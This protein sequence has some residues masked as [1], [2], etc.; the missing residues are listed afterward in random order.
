MGYPE[1][2]PN[3]CWSPRGDH[4]STN[5]GRTPAK[6]HAVA[7]PPNADPCSSPTP[8]ALFTADQ[9]KALAGLL[10]ND[11]LPPERLNGMFPSHSWIIDTG[12][13]HHVTIE[14]FWFSDLI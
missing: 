14:E 10:G 7:I 12:A 9:W 2:G 13:T 8:S 5:R 6:T 4:P 3:S 1:N 11:Q